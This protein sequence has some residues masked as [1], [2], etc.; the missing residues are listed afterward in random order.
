MTRPLADDFMQVFKFHAE[1]V[2]E[3]S[4]EDRFTVAGQTQAGFSNITTPELTVEAAEYSEGQ[5]IYG[6]K[7]PGKPTVSDCTFSR[8][9]TK[10]L[11]PFWAWTRQVAEGSGNYRAE[12]LIHQYH[13]QE[14][15]TRPFPVTQFTENLVR[16]PENA[17]P[18]ITI[19]LYEA[20]PTRA[21]IVGD[22]DATGSDISISEMD[23]VLE[24]FEIEEGA[25]ATP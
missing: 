20:F 4:T 17:V 18:T 21:K 25:A 15:L 16:I 10:R 13:R 7:Q 8:G 24:H 19:H 2:V 3:G 22:L 5:R 11:S 6:M 9:Q 1:A 12:V 14:A 23:V